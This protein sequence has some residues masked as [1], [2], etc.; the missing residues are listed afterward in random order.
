[1]SGCDGGSGGFAFIV[2]LFLL[3]IIVECS[4]GSVPDRA[5]SD[6]NSMQKA[7]LYWS[8][9]SNLIPISREGFLLGI[10]VVS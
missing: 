3:L 9:F 8:A 2:V 10:L 7:D 6:K 1:M 5:P 4:C